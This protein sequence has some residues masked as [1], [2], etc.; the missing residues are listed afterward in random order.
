MD[1][2]HSEDL[3]YSN[4]LTLSYWLRDR[5]WPIRTAWKKPDGRS[6]YAFDHKAEVDLRD[7]TIARTAIFAFDREMQ[8]GAGR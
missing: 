2:Q 6:G 4:R 5:G 7:Y 1:T 3:F 8:Q